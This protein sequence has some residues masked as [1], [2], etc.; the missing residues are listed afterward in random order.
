MGSLHIDWIG[1]A[2]PVQAEGTVDDRQFYFRARHS[3]WRLDI[4]TDASGPHG[5]TAWSY[6]EVYGEGP[7]DAGWMT[8]DE[9]RALIDRAAAIWREQQPLS[10]KWRDSIVRH[11]A[12][13]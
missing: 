13:S 5:K 1:G 7:Y 6:G 3:E 11:G 9:A 4:A 2:C 10:H 12:P 8:E